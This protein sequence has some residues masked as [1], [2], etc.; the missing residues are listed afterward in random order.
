M[1]SS[2]APGSLNHLYSSF[3]CKSFV[4]C[5]HFKYIMLKQN[6]ETC[7]LSCVA[8]CKK[9]LH[10]SLMEAQRL[11]RP[12]LDCHRAS[13]GQSRNPEKEKRIKFREEMCKV[14]DLNHTS[15]TI[16]FICLSSVHHR[17]CSSLLT[18]IE[19]GRASWSFTRETSR[20]DAAVWIVLQGFSVSRPHYASYKFEI[21]TGFSFVKVVL[22]QE[23]HKQ[24]YWLSSQISLCKSTKPSILRTRQNNP[25]CPFGWSVVLWCHEALSTFGLLLCWRGGDIS[26]V[27]L[28]LFLACSCPVR[29][30]Q[31]EMG[32]DTKALVQPEMAGTSKNFSAIAKFLFFSRAWNLFSSARHV[33]RQFV[34]GLQGKAD[35]LPINIPIIQQ[36]FHQIKMQTLTFCFSAWRNLAHGNYR[37]IEFASVRKKTDSVP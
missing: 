1:A 30:W 20:F 33:I 16:Q 18:S 26:G 37:G 31:T 15:W 6:F 2:S 4:L 21:A 11:N 9:S 28:S 5:R 27:K 24:T 35:R 13:L 19:S 34:Q 12:S 8:H 17:R 3:W 36:E 32:S 7:S 25:N 10:P 29:G 23:Y 22:Q 14:K